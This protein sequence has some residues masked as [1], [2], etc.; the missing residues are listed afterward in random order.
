M[1]IAPLCPSYGA[2]PLR[3][4]TRRMSSG[5]L[6]DAYQSRPQKKVPSTGDEAEA[7]RFAGI[8]P[9]R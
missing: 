4:A 5:R 1:G 7:K 8:R 2:A 6:P 9:A 3:C